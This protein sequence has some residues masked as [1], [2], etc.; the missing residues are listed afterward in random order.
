VRQPLTWTAAVAVGAA[1]W[2]FGTHA[3]FRENGY[4]VFEAALQPAAK[5]ASFFLL[6][7]ASVAVAG[8]RT[9]GTVRWIL[10]RPLSRAA[11]VLGKAG[12]HALLCLVLLLVAVGTSWAVAAG[13]GFGD[14][15]SDTGGGVADGFNFVEE[16]D[17]PPEFSADTMRR[18]TV[19]AALLVLPALLSATGIGLLVSSLLSSAAG[20]VIVSI[21]VALPLYYLPEV[22]N[23][24]AGTATVL[25][26]RAATDFLGQILE[27]GRRLATARWPHYGAGAAAGAILGAF[28]LPL[29]AAYLFS[30]IDLTE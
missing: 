10:P 9:R 6:G 27:F 24:P 4:V 15:V 11:F 16:E 5:V 17:V 21:A 20:A 30:R 3:P 2:I 14:V 25:P 22:I 18:R 8:E 28:G 19:I 13:H 23:L 12:A 29:L 1:A 26:F 7:I